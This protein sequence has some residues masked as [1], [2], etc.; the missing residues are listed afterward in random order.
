MTGSS[1][2]SWSRAPILLLLARLGLR[3]HEAAGLELED[4]R[5]RTGTIVVRRK[6]GRSE[7]LPLAR[8]I[9]SFQDRHA[10]DLGGHVED[11][12]VDVTAVA[13]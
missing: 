13:A 3:A 12:V 1:A 10:V 7:E 2:A 9:F 8:I 6:G 11:G 5:W 4:I